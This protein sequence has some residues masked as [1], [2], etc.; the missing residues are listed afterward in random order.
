M[1]G[2][3]TSHSVRGVIGEMRSFVVAEL[4]T[5]DPGD[6]PTDAHTL[7]TMEE[8]AKMTVS[9]SSKIFEDFTIVSYVT[10]VN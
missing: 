3:L 6:F 8:I 9:A 5:N 1:P 2:R 10:L 7:G 4:D